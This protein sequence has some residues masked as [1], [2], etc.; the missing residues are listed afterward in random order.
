MQH[1]NPPKHKAWAGTDTFARAGDCTEVHMVEDDTEPRELNDGDDAC[2][3]G[4]V[5]YSGGTGLPEATA[6]HMPDRA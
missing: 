3:A 6:R 1:A 2:G 5:T 4:A